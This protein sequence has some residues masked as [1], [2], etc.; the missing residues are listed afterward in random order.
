[1]STFGNMDY[2]K[3]LKKLLIGKYY[4]EAMC[5]QGDLRQVLFENLFF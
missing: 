4:E 2:H 5:R 3:H 1:M